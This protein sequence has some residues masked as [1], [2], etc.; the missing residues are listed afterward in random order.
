[1]AIPQ[2]T[3][4]RNARFNGITAATEA[5]AAVMG[6][7]ETVVAPHARRAKAAATC[8]QTFGAVAEGLAWLIDQGGN[9]AERGIAMELHASLNELTDRYAVP[10]RESVAMEAPPPR[11]H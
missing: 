9:G 11:V 10:K 4:G 5:L 8:V 3:F 1:M 6:H 2:A 7:G